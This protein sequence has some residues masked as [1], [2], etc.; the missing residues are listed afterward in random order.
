MWTCPK[1]G[2][3]VDASFDVCWHCGT[4]ADGTADPSFVSADQTGP[5]DEL[6]APTSPDLKVPLSQAASVAASPS[7]ELVACYQTYS[8]MEAQFLANELSDNGID[9]VCDE[10][11]MQDAIG[12]WSGNPRVYCREGDLARARVFL[13]TYEQKRAGHRSSP[14]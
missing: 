8:L 12:G 4:A 6:P 11:D 14:G 3:K 10:Q 5:I 1:C 7:S 2:S 13:E 9:A